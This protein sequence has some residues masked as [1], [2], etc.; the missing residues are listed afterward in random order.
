[1]NYYRILLPC[2]VGSLAVSSCGGVQQRDQ[3]NIISNTTLIMVWAL[4]FMEEELK[5]NTPFFTLVWFHTPHTPVVAG[6]EH[7]ELYSGLTMEAKHWYGCIT[8][9]DEQ[10]GRLLQSL[11]DWGVADETI[12]WFISNNGP[13]YIHGLNSAGPLHGAK[14]ELY[15]GGIRVPSILHWPAQFPDPK[16]I[17]EP[18][19]PG[20]NSN[21]HEIMTS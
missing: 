18:M 20:C 11:A 19:H 6:H 17:N 3:P 1:M 15:K 8:A 21:N 13:S 7:R 16:E 5:A 14:G 12:V 2:L 4:A 9:M 10:I